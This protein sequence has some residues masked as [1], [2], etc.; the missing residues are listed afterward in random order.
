MANAFKGRGFSTQGF[1]QARRHASGLV[2]ALRLGTP[3]SYALQ[4]AVTEGS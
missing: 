3:S 2:D 4:T 1:Q